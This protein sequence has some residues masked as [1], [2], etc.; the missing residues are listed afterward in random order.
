MKKKY[1]L[2]TDSF[3]SYFFVENDKIVKADLP[4]D[5]F[6]FDHITKLFDWL[7]FNCPGYRI[8]PPSSKY[9]VIS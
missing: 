5:Y 6:L 9:E 3:R 7:D 2:I 4:L 8:I 1:L